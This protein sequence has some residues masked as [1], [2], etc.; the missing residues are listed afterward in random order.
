MKFVDK[1]AIVTGAGRGIGEDYARAL[2][3]AGASLVVA[4]IDQE[5]GRRVVEA[6]VAD[7]GKAIFSAC[8]VSSEDDAA[9]TVAMA[10]EAFGGVDFLVN[11]AAIYGGMRRESL[12]GVDLAYYRRF[13]DV[14]M[15]GALV[16]TRAVVA[17]M[18]ARGGGAIIN[19][20]STAAY[21]AG[22]YYGLA[23]LGLNGLT[24]SLAGELGP[25]NIRING[26]APGPVP[27]EATNTSV[28]AAVIEGIVEKLPLRRLGSTQDMVNACLFL[29]SAEA[30]WITG[31]TLC[32]DGGMIRRAS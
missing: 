19:Q 23:K 18:E 25:R 7:G 26:I 17:A 20:S 24:V 15:N 14:N 12:L 29:L 32:V 30:G 28:P 31:Q 2:A 5:N 27:T 6:I 3:Q 13:M 21:T 22:N 1:V 16:M 4:D 11:N 8:D 10:N 9:S